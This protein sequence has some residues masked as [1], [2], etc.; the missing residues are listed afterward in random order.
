[1]AS[2]KSR[3]GAKNRVTVD[4]ISEGKSKGKIID[5]TGK[6]NA[7]QYIEIINGVGYA[8]FL[9]YGYSRQAPYGMVRI[10]MAEMRK[11]TLPKDLGKRLQARWNRFY[12]GPTGSWR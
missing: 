7:L 3:K 8:L 11:G 4:A 9:E 12:Y 10:S 1:M 5:K 2:P 6:M